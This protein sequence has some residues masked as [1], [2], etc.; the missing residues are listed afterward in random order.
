MGLSV[1]EF[2]DLTPR[3]LQMCFEADTWRQTQQVRRDTRI[4]W[5]IAALGRM[6]RLPPL[7]T[8]LDG[9]QAKPLRG[10]ELKR[11]R[12]EHEDIKKRLGHGQRN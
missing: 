4:A 1:A 3:E 10:E 2:W 8:M 7:Q 6:K 11:R 9:G 12:A 5:H